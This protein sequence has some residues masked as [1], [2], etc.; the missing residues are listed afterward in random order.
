MNSGRSPVTIGHRGYLKKRK[1]KLFIRSLIIFLG[2][3]GLIVT[4]YFVTGTL[5]NWFTILG[6]V[7]AIPFAMMLSTLIAMLKFKAPEEAEYESVR[8]ITGNGVLDTEILI[9]NKD[10]ASFYFPYVY[11]HE[12]GIF[13]YLVNEKADPEKTSEYVRNYLRLN[14][15]DAPFTVEKDLAAFLNRIGGLSPSDRE[16]VLEKVLREEGVV[17]AISM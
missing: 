4:G 6:L 15:A 13:G 11:F 9:A 7:T 17:R 10:G 1:L 3:A 2:A 16:T 14:D 12:D 5:K 8:K